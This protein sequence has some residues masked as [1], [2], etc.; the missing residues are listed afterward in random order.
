M[1]KDFHKLAVKYA[2]EPEKFWRSNTIRKYFNS[3]IFGFHRAQRLP[4]A[5]VV[6]LYSPKMSLLAR[7]D[8]SAYYINA[9]NAYFKNSSIQ[10]TFTYIHGLLFHEIG[11]R[12]YTSWTTSKNAELAL[13]RESFYPSTPLIPKEYEER[14]KLFME[15]LSDKRKR[16]AIGRFA[17]NLINKVEDG[18]NENLL[19]KTNTSLFIN[20]LNSYRA[21]AKPKDYSVIEQPYV[22]N[23]KD[24]VVLSNLCWLAAVY[25]EKQVP[26]HLARLSDRFQELLPYIQKYIDAPNNQVLMDSFN[27]LL[28]LMAP[29]LKDWLIVTDMA[30]SSLDDDTDD[31][32]VL[33]ENSVPIEAEDPSQGKP[34]DPMNSPYKKPTKDID[35]EASNSN[36]QNQSQQ[37]GSQ[38][39]SGNSSD[40]ADDE[41]G[42]D[43]TNSSDD[44]TSD[45]SNSSDKNASGSN[46]SSSESNEANSNEESDTSNGSASDSSD[47]SDV[48]DNG[49]GSTDLDTAEDMFDENSDSSSDSESD[50]SDTTDE[51][52]DSGSS[53]NS[54]D[55]SDGESEDETDTDSDF[56]NLLKALKAY[57][58]EERDSSDSSEEVSD[59]SAELYAE[60]ML[61]DNKN[62]DSNSE[63]DTPSPLDEL[64]SEEY[65]E[66]L[67]EMMRSKSELSDYEYG[68]QIQDKSFDDLRKDLTEE[69]E[70]NIQN[71]DINQL[72]Q[73]A[74]ESM[75]YGED[76]SKRPAVF[77][78]VDD[79][80]E[81]Y[82]RIYRDILQ[83]THPASKVFQKKAAFYCKNP[84]STI[85]PGYSGKKFNAA[86]IANKSGRNF[87]KEVKGLES[88][89][90]VVCC[91]MDQS[92]ST[93]DIIYE[94]RDTAIFLE[95]SCRELDIP[96]Y[97]MGTSTD[98]GGASA[99]FLYCDPTHPDKDD[100]YRLATISS[101][102]ANCDGFALR[103]AY[104]RL[105]DDYPVADKIIIYINDGQ[106]NAY[107]YGGEKAERDLRSFTKMCEKNHVNLLVA[108]VGTDK[109]TLER[110]Y[111]KEHFIDISNLTTLS[112]V[113]ANRIK[114]MMK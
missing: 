60:E 91:L 23:D 108:G 7:T 59:E 50:S 71:E 98:G 35:D 33:D 65:Q 10:D 22:D 32:A 13:K 68:S 24:I 44:S 12:I 45:S 54:S 61:P 78:R 43:G 110:I 58:K 14:Y 112:T 72:Y 76:L 21:F 2:N 46:D 88:N 105:M 97:C 64:S 74:A 49:S 96:F 77:I 87:K 53:S 17:R 85:V 41:A 27:M 99:I 29:E 94:M 114:K 67:N 107:D 16:F 31:E 66:I 51:S 82:K 70:N 25:G 89:D 93:S 113:L 103:L 104:K 62:D 57:Q 40:Q 55:N 36:S 9:G 11:H 63:C 95:E 8:N 3:V 37:N 100:K 34:F 56:E 30:G 101:V 1:K 39:S 5:P 86:A 81:Y 15:L 79:V 47:I 48:D 111:G 92:G 26:S 80:P 52:A 69:F 83:K 109:Q 4:M 102:A 90:V 18:R 75:D 42:D 73:D 38:S 6:L 19:R 20:G 106:P 84:D 28:I